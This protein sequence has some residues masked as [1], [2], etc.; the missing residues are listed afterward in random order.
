MVECRK[1]S[2]IPC[3][4][5]CHFSEK[6]IA[7]DN[8][9]ER[10]SRSSQSSNSGTNYGSSGGNSGN[11]DCFIVTLCYGRD[12]DIYHKMID[13][14]DEF[15]SEYLIGRLFI[16]SYYAVSPWLVR[17]IGRSDFLSEVSRKAVKWALHR[18][19]SLRERVKE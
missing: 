7:I 19:V 9:Q 6:L 8:N 3:T 1:T 11:S 16:K 15:L 14:R 18:L 13:L 2:S 17:I 12:S 4:F 5:K 10:R